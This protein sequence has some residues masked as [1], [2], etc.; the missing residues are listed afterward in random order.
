MSFN[1]SVLVEAF[2]Q[3]NEFRACMLDNL[4]HSNSKLRES[5]ALD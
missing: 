5:L 4:S 1:S 3:T 2:N